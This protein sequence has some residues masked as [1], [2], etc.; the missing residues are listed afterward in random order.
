MNKIELYSPEDYARAFSERKKRLMGIWGLCA[1]MIALFA[2]STVL[3]LRIPGL[4]VTVALACVSYFLYSIKV[5]PYLKYC[6]YLREMRD[7]LT[8]ETDGR[9]GYISQDC[10]MVDG[11]E[12]CDFIL[13]VGDGETDERLFLWDL[14]KPRPHLPEGQMLRVASHSNFIKSFEVL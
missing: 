6:K 3:R 1:L 4:V 7:G 10:R 8:R 14:D 12:V 11:V 5:Q 13:H 9:F 2:A